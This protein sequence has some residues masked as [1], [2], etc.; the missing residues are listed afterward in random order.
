MYKERLIST[1]LFIKKHQHH[2][3]CSFKISTLSPTLD[4]MCQDEI[5]DIQ[6]DQYRHLTNMMSIKTKRER[7]ST[8]I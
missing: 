7:H 6:E 5:A 1:I 2:P 3:L 8:H 4:S